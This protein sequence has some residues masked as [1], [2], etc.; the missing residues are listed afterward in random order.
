MFHHPHKVSWFGIPGPFDYGVRHVCGDGV[1]LRSVCLSVERAQ[2]CVVDAR[3][4]VGGVL[5]LA[6]FLIF[7]YKLIST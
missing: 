1:C 3:V 2:T 4:G 7:K 6:H 5:V